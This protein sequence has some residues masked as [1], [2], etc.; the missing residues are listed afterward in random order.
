MTA[1]RSNDL[2]LAALIVSIIAHI[3]VMYYM[4]SHTMAQLP[5]QI[6]RTR[7]HVPMQMG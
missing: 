1:E 6:H 3:G 2:A 4:S 5:P 7:N